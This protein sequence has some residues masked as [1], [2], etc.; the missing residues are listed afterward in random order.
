MADH[1]YTSPAEPPRQTRRNL[2][3]GLL[4]GSEEGLGD[5]SLSTGASGTTTAQGDTAVLAAPDLQTRA[6]KTAE[7]YSFRGLASL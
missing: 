7:W 1:A 4:Y 5:P 6:R 2:Y 3:T